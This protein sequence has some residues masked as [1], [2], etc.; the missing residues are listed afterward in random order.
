MTNVID[1]G[2]ERTYR[3]D[4]VVIDILLALFGLTV[5]GAVIAFLLSDLP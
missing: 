5:I 2:L 4:D 3:A 1:L